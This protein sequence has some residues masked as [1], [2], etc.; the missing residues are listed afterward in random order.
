MFLS[1]P[2]WQI[3]VSINRVTREAGS[4][5]GGQAAP[6]ISFIRVESDAFRSH[7]TGDAGGAM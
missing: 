4:Q 5:T 3:N 7:P 1:L 2:D 6:D